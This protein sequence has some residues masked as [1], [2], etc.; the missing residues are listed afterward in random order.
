MQIKSTM[1]ESELCVAGLFYRMS[2]L[3][4]AVSGDPWMLRELPTAAVLTCWN[5]DGTPKGLLIYHDVVIP[6]KEDVKYTMIM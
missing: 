6:Y 2:L 3:D 1:L 5:V 4:D